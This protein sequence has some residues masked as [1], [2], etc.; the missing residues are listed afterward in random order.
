MVWAKS[1]TEYN[2]KHKF[3]NSTVELYQDERTKTLEENFGETSQ[4]I[5]IARLLPAPGPIKNPFGISAC[6]ATTSKL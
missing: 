5:P 2:F 3:K 1:I 6:F 4:L